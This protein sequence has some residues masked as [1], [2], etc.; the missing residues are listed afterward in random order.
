M[1]TSGV[2]FLAINAFTQYFEYFQDEPW[3]LIF[4]GI[5][6]VAVALGLVRWELRKRPNAGNP[7]PLTGEN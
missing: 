1:A 3:A 5:A 6:L 2:V 7:M 4:G